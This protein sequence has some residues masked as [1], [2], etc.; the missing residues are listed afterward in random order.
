MH[1]NDAEVRIKSLAIT[2]RGLRRT[3]R[4]TGRSVYKR[5]GKSI[6]QNNSQYHP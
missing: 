4:K 6:C 2:I 5:S 1:C 3:R